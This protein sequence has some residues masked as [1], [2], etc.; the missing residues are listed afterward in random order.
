MTQRTL[1]KLA[2]PAH[3]KESADAVA[4]VIK[5]GMLIAGKEVEG[6]EKRL[7]EITDSPYAVMLS[8]GTGALLAA[9]ASMG[10]GKGSR[11]LVSGFTF[12]APAMVAE[13]LGAGVDIIDVDPGTFNVSVKGVVEAISQKEAVDLII[14]VDQFGAPAPLDE[15]EKICSEKKIPLLVDSA[16]SLGSSIGGRMCGT[17][18]D[19][20]I[21]SFHPRK[22]ITTGE[23]GAMLTSNADLYNKVKKFRS[24]GF[25]N[26]QFNSRGIN[27]RPGEMGAAMGNVQ[28]DHFGEIIEKRKY[29]FE[30]YKELPLR[31]QKIID[32]TVTNYQTVAALVPG[33][34]STHKRAEFIEFM[35]NNQIETSIAGYSLSKVAWLKN[36]F[37]YTVCDAPNSSRLHDLGVALPMHFNM[38]KDD[39]VYIVSVVK[40]WLGGKN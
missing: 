23:G 27:L 30:F 40:K 28:L 33:I 11:V 17:F 34:D 24:F 29:L 26:G 9:M 36:R 20:S 6:F 12:P 7:C 19:A 22:I 37:G 38:E 14:I 15:I 1:I 32:G 4:A 21:F 16:C 13:F 31:F 35:A 2:S 5:S 10:I 39:I 3:F 18:G 8:S 25:E